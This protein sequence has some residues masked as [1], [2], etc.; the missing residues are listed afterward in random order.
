MPSIPAQTSAQARLIFWRR[1]NM[2]PDYQGFRPQ[3]AS[4]LRSNPRAAVAQVAFHVFEL[5]MAY[6]FAVH[7]V[8]HVFADVLGVIADALERTHDPHDVERAPDAARIFHHEGDAL[9]LDGFVFFVYHAILACD[10]QRCLAVHSGEGVERLMHH[11]RDDAAE[12]LD[13]AILVGRA[14]H[15]G[16]PR[17]D[18]ADLLAFIA[19]AFQ[20]GDRLDDCHDEAQV[21]RGRR[22]CRK[23]ARTFLVDGHFHAVDLEVVASHGNAQVAVTF[24]ERGHGVGKLLLDHAAHGQHL[25]PYALQVFVEAARDVVGQISGFHDDPQETRLLGTG[26]NAPLEHA[27]IRKM[28]GEGATTAFNAVDIEAAAVAMQCMFDDRESKA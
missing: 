1:S 9:A 22:A 18:V 16:E 20:V 24:D 28:A 21:T 23:D 11:L 4:A 27:F 6:V 19:D 3:T 12:M 14:L 17:G 25:V 13:L 15:A 2:A 10:P 5:G 8:D 26:G 7:H